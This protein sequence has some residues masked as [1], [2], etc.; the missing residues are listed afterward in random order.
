MIGHDHL[1]DF[2]M[3]IMRTLQ[4]I[5]VGYFNQA[6][7][8]GGAVALPDY[9]RIEDAVRHRTWRIYLSYR[10]TTWKPKPHLER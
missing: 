2:L 6:L 9:S 8:F 7:Q 10:H 3:R 5:T 1:A 4:L